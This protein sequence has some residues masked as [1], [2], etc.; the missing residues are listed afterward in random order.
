MIWPQQTNTQ[1]SARI[2]YETYVR[3]L[4]QRISPE[5]NGLFED[6]IFIC[7]FVNENFYILIRISPKFVPKDPIDDNPALV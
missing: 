3:G 5:K 6:D 2:S 1:Q 7:I 4:L